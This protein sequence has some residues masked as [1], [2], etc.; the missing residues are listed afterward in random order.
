MRSICIPGRVDDSVSGLCSQKENSER[1]D[2]AW[3]PTKLGRSA[4]EWPVPC[5]SELG[6]AGRSW[7][8]RGLKWHML[9]RAPRGALSTRVSAV[10]IGNEKY[11]LIQGHPNPDSVHQTMSPQASGLVCA[12]PMCTLES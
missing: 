10:Q 5:R 9:V 4:E 7:A 1:H 6:V 8:T 11:T 3:L 2:V 12:W